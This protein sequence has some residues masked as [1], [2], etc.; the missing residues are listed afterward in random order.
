MPALGTKPGKL[1]HMVQL[2]VV[3]TKNTRWVDMAALLIA[4]RG[5][6][7]EDSFAL[8]I[9]NE[10]KKRAYRGRPAEARDILVSLPY[11]LLNC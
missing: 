11:I 10:R 3:L 9:S 4:A 5:Y 2:R 1:S 8:R 7:P 6:R